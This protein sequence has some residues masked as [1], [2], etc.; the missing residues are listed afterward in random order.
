MASARISTAP[1]K[2]GNELRELARSSAAVVRLID[3]VANCRS[4]GCG[5]DYIEEI[6]HTARAVYTFVIADFG[7][8]G[9]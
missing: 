2:K 9:D 6:V 8:W 3:A 4:I 5:S 1:S 7:D